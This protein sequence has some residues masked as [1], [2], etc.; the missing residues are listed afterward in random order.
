MSNVWTL[1]HVFATRAD[2]H[3]ERIM[4][5]AGGRTWTYGQVQA[6]ATALAAA[7]AELGI[8]MGDRVAINL[9]NWPEWIITLLAASRLGATIVP[10]NPQLNYHELKYQLRHAE[11]SV[12][13]TAERFRDTDYLQL[14]EDL[15]AELP[16]LQ[17]VVTVGEEELWY[18]D[19]IFQFEDLVSSGEGRPVPVALDLRDDTTLTMIYTSG[20]MG[21]PK[22]VCLSNRSIVE[23]AVRSFEAIE[24]E[25]A[26]RV[27]AAVPLFAV[28]GFGVAV[29]TLAAGATLVLE[30]TFH[31]GEAIEL[32]A[33]EKISLL[34]GVPTMYHLLMREAT[35]EPSRFRHLRSGV[36]AGNSASPDM[37]RRIRKWCDVQIAYGLTETGP[38]VSITRFTDPEEKRASTVGR[39][40]PGVEVRAVDF[41][42]GALH[43][44]EAVGEI[45]VRG[46]NV[47]QGYARMPGETA[48]SFTPEGF[49]LTGDLGFID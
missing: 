7:L 24:I 15:I 48:R 37:V 28:F 13:V 45:A 2:A 35:F 32:I 17:Y 41:R 31:A 34:P 12:A 6:R 8:G 46:F 29:G 14:F 33:R 42:T 5:V 30:E 49:F 10:V 23:T 44:P 18:D 39:P 36:I 38:T 43:G 25:P 3:P 20:T 1:D 21:K 27:L 47:M 4:L 9:P 11:V 40:L 16:D 22:G 26:D 19:R